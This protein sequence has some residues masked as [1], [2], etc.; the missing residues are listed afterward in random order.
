MCEKRG[1]KEYTQNDL[2]EWSLAERSHNSEKDLH[3]PKTL[4]LPSGRQLV[5]LELLDD[6]YPGF[7]V[8]W[9]YNTHHQPTHTHTHTHTHKERGWSMVVI[10]EALPSSATCFPR[11]NQ[12]GAA[13]ELPLR[14]ANSEANR[15][16]CSK[17]RDAI[18]ADFGACNGT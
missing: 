10:C 3:E 17:R 8:P 16:E 2:A 5:A 15:N 13:Y 18:A 6:P 14:N 1:F 9:T 7:G 12:R 11:C 4:Y